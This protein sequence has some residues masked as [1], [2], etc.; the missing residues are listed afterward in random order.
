[1]IIP[2]FVMYGGCPNRCV[3]CN[4]AKTAGDRRGT[5][6]AEALR[7]TVQAHLSTA[8]AG[9]RVQI[10]FYG[11]SFTGMDRGYQTELLDMARSFVL[12]GL[13]SGIR[14]STRP[15]YIDEARIALLE[16]FRVTAVEIGAQSLVDAVLVRAQRGH[17]AADIRKAVTL[18]KDRGFE[19]A[20]QLMAGLPGDSPEGFD[21]T[22]RETIALAPHAVRIHPTIVLADTP[23][24]DAYLRGEYEPMTMNEAVETCKAALRRFAAAGIPVIRIGLQT[25]AEMEAAGGVIAGP[26]HPAFRSLVEESLFLDMAAALLS[27]APDLADEAS[28]ILSPR[29]ISNLRG[30]KNGNIR[31]L[32]ARFGLKNIDI[33]PDPGRSR[34]TLSLSCNGKACSEVSLAS[35]PA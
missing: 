35:L 6:S 25:T 23:L 13:V 1:M 29:D 30:R 20:V 4:V 34:G 12:R 16:E 17:T 24:A 18:L 27:S 14:V 33:L 3:F 22:V 32:K 26:F 28:F 19:T 31:L 9:E 10:A 15:D 2:L 11:G 21:F 7:A 5:G 8:R